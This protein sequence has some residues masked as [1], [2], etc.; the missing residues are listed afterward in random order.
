MSRGKAAAADGQSSVISR[1]PPKTTTAPI[2][3][4][5]SIPLPALI[6]DILRRK[7][8]DTIMDEA[9]LD[10]GPSDDVL[11]EL[12][13]MQSEE[14]EQAA[15]A[16]AAAEQAEAL[17]GEVDEDTSDDS[18]DDSSDDTSDDGEEE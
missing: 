2:T 8:L 13:L 9:T 3:S 16:A 10:G 15:R 12:G 11:T 6:G 7:A 4:P 18:S 5:A 14:D 17:A 1:A